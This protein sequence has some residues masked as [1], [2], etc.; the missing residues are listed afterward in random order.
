MGEEAKYDLADKKT[1]QDETTQLIDK[2]EI[3]ALVSRASALREGIP[4]S[5][6]HDLQYD[7]SMRESVISR[8]N[9]HV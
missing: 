6:A 4:C 2:I 8:M 9:L 3:S 7:T 5:T 1:E